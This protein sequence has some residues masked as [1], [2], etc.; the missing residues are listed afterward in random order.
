[1]RIDDKFKDEKLKY[2]INRE[3]TENINITIMKIW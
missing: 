2:D 1:M 3:A